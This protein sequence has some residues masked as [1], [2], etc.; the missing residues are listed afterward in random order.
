MT[1]NELAPEAVQTK[2]RRS[3]LCAIVQVA[4]FFGTVYLAII[5]K[6]QPGHEGG[7]PYELALRCIAIA[8]AIACAAS[9]LMKL[10]WVVPFA[11]IGCFLGAA[12][13]VIDGEPADLI[14]HAASGAIG[15]AAFGI[16]LAAICRWKR[17][18][19]IF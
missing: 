5:C 14:C 15:G 18:F 1:A 13:P 10:G 3:L 11:V 17:G 8:L 6:D 2:P 7:D 12:M 4:L 9:F 19:Q 16:A